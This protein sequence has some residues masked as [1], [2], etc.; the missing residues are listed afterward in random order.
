MSFEIKTDEFS[1]PLHLLLE[2]IEREELDITEVSLAR[3][4]EE[5]LAYVSNNDVP[6]EELA[7]FLVVASRLLYIKSKAIL[8]EIDF[9]EEEEGDLAAQLKMYREFVKA[10]QVLYEIYRD[11]R[12]MYGRERAPKVRSLEFSPPKKLKVNDLTRAMEM[13]IKKLEPFLRLKRASLE[14]VV[15][16]QERIGNIRE[17]I[18]NRANLSFRDLTGSSASKADTVVSFLALLEL[19]KQRIV[20]AAQGDLFSDINIKR[21]D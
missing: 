13:I 15:S 14:R 1:G 16:I 21:I 18:I 8:P 3:V 17:A 12:V 6:A 2:I 11:Q 5:Y 20:H 7:D 9:E 10:S 4:T 19:V